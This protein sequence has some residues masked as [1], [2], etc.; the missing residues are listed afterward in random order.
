MTSGNQAIHDPATEEITSV[1]SLQD[2][3]VR[4]SAMRVKMVGFT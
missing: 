2:M 4:L 1:Q 3:I